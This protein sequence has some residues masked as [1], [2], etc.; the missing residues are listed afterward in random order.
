MDQLVRESAIIYG[1]LFAIVGPSECNP[2]LSIFERSLA[3]K[4]RIA[5]EQ[6]CKS[7]EAWE[8]KT[9]EYVCGA[10]DSLSYTQINSAV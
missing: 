4:L 1:V 8:D 3:A 10:M 2:E 5:L 9:V 7:L 6:I